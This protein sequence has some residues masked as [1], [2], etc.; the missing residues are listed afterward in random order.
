MFSFEKELEFN[1]LYF[2]KTLKNDK[3]FPIKNILSVV[4][5]MK[6]TETHS[7]TL[8]E[9]F[10][11]TTFTGPPDQNSD[12]RTARERLEVSLERTHTH[13][14]AHRHTSARK[15]GDVAMNPGKCF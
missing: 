10:P 6:W 4:K 7:D 3:E 13:T 5:N 11:L 15:G 1:F 12:P 2:L 14:C 8:A 9:M